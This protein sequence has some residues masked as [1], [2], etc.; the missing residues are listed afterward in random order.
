MTSL[1]SAG[2]SGRSD[3]DDGAPSDDAWRLR[4]QRQTMATAGDDFDDDDVNMLRS[5]G[6][7][8]V[9][10]R[11]DDHSR[12]LVCDGCNGEYHTYCLSP[13]LSKIPAHDWFCGTFDRLHYH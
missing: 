2:A 10:G 7:C 1:S 4:L 5:S 11:D 9:C 12:T 8:V 13:V 3:S 6:G